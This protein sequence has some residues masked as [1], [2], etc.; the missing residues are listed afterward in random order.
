MAFVLPAVP[1]IVEAIGAGLIALGVIGTGAVVADQ[2]SKANKRAKT[3]SDAAPATTCQSCRNNPCAA[4][5]GGTPGTRYKGGAHGIMKGP[6]GDGLDS[7]HI[8]A[9]DVSPLPR[10]MGPAIKMDPADHQ[11]T[12]SHGSGRSAVAY[13]AAQKRLIDSGNFAGA[14]AMDVADVK[15][16][17]GSKYDGAIAQAGAYMACLKRNGVVR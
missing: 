12:A 8:P 6:T 16:K 9:A 5:A 3:M 14:F 13:R 1:P 17:F 2:V 10:D 4:L 15:A 11:L 7:H